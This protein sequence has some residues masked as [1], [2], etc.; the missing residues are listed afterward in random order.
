M[1]ENLIPKD[2]YLSAYCLN[3]VMRISVEKLQ[4]LREGLEI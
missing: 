4:K 2:A 1:E 3:W